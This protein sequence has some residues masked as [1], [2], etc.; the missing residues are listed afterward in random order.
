MLLMK[1]SKGHETRTLRVA[2]TFQFCHVMCVFRNFSR[3]P[4]TPK[5]GETDL[6]NKIY[7][8]YEDSARTA[9]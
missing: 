1:F 9:Q 7:L 6:K 8:N 4:K 2:N 3:T 5:T